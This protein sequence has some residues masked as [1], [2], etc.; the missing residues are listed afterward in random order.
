M[1]NLRFILL[2]SLCCWSTLS[3]SEPLQLQA[4]TD[5]KNLDSGAVP[6]YQDTAGARNALA[7]N[8]AI[9]SY[10][11]VFARAEYEFN[12]EDGLYDITI[13]AL[14]E[15]D[16]D[17]TYRLLVDGVL[18]GSSV[19]HPVSEDYTVIPHEFE[20]VALSS[21]TVIGIE[22]NAVSNN[23]I[24]E[25]DGYAFARGRWRSLTIES[26]SNDGTTEQITPVYDLAIALST[27]DSLLQTDTEIPLI[28]TVVNHSTEVTATSPSVL[29][30]LPEEVH[31]V[32]SEQCAPR[33]YGT[34]CMLPELAPGDIE[35]VRFNATIARDGWHS[36]SAS[37][38]SDQAENDNS[39]NTDVLSF[40][41]VKSP[42]NESTMS[43]SVGEHVQSIES[44]AVEP[45]PEVQAETQAQTLAP[46][47]GTSETDTDSDAGSTSVWVIPPV[48]FML[49]GRRI[50]LRRRAAR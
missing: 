43:A 33:K 17:G 47:T 40:F 38:S 44:T 4:I 32:S 18:Q 45:T 46:Q 28:A 10:R 19:N 25:G 15:I 8:A 31:F 12:G 7:I 24:P 23:T 1:C 37:V 9:E 39:N 3:A 48:F 36:I 22:S 14:G 16:G 41:V 20:S 49:L 6:Y 42:A 26:T 30:S 34:T 29:F 35:H 11:H 21:G 50:V 27:V 2:T 13:N 5:F